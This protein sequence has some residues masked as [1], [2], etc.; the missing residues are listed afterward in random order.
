MRQRKSTKFM[1][2]KF[3]NKC[4][5]IHELVA[6]VLERLLFQRFTSFLSQEEQDFATTGPTASAN[7]D[8]KWFFRQENEE[9][10]AFCNRHNKFFDNALNGNFGKT[11][12][13]STIYIFFI[14]RIDRDFQRCVRTNDVGGYIDVLPPVLD[15][16]FAL[17]RSN[18]ARYGTLFLHLL[19]NAGTELTNILN[20]GAFSIRRTHKNYSRTAVDLSLEQSYNRDAASATKGIVAF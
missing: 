5:R 13:Y 9:F 20:G 3:C 11:T 17:N 7:S 10:I 12:Q 19:Q 16:L 1:K 2:G 14:H 4:Q 6:I 18:Y 15:L 8:K